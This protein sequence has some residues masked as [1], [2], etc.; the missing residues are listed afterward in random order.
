MLYPGIE[1]GDAFQ[2][3]HMKYII[4]ISPE[5]SWLDVAIALK[6]RERIYFS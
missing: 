4:S 2:P 1:I 3:S 5:A 6:A